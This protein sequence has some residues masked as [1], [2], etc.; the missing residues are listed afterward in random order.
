MSC[1][2]GETG[3]HPW[4]PL[5]T[6]A[7]SQVGKL[8]GPQKATN[9]LESRTDLNNMEYS[10]VAPDPD[11]LVTNGSKI[12]RGPGEDNSADSAFQ[13]HSESRGRNEAQQAYTPKRFYGRRLAKTSMQ[14]NVYNFLER[15]TGWKCFIYHFT[16]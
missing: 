1:A 10:P 6:S 7:S 12:L 2:N 9:W 3:G 15:P 13:I 16:V 4:C 5:S 8:N 14:G 11:S